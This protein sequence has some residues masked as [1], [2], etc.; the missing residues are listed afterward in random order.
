MFILRTNVIATLRDKI[1]VF[2]TLSFQK[3]NCYCI[4]LTNNDND[5]CFTATFVHKVGQ[6]GMGQAISK[7]NETKWKVKQPSDMPT[8]GFERGW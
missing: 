3:K 8:P 1:N 2:L 4:F 6:M 5:W 7:G